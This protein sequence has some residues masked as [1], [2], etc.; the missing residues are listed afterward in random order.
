MGLGDAIMATGEVNEL[1]KKNPDTKFLIGDGKNEYWNEVFINN[2][3]IIR[4]YEI[5]NHKKVYWLKNYEGNRPYRNYDK[6]KLPD[7]YNWNI[8][9]KAKKGEIFFNSNEIKLASD[10]ISKIKNKVGDKK[11]IF[12]EPYVK[13]RRGYQNRDW[14]VKNWQKVVSSLKNQYV[15]LHITHGDLAPLRDCINIHGLSFRPSVAILSKCDLFIGTEG[16]MHHAAAATSRK[17]V[18]IFGGHIS[19]KITGYDFHKNLYVDI[20]G[21]PCGKKNICDHCKKCMQ[22]ISFTKVI[23]EI[24]E[25]LK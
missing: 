22:L 20:E 23:K 10:V 9:Y 24:E 8:N 17:A 25:T 14:G 12:I 11:I 19:P 16:G 13:K 6:N 21:S 2:P 15:F 3:N 5:K 7:N 18:V 4:K 1:L